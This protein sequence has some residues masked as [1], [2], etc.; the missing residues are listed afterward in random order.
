VLS[1]KEFIQQFESA[2]AEKNWPAITALDKRMREVVSNEQALLQS[3]AGSDPANTQNMPDRLS[4]QLTQL[5]QLYQQ[6]ELLAEQLK[7]QTGE[8]IQSLGAGK[9]GV[10]AYQDN[11]RL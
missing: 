11:A 9:A 1:L 8:Q 3:T 4:G 5:R 6:A 10:S 7:L 2:L